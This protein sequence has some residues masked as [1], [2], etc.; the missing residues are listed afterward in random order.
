MAAIIF[1]AVDMSR[2]PVD[3]GTTYLPY[4]AVVTIAAEDLM[5][6]RLDPSPIISTTMW[7]NLSLA[8]RERNAS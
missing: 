7:P 6:D 8:T 4:V 5:L 2:S 3:A 1:I